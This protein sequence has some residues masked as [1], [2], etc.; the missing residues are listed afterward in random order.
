MSISVSTNIRLSGAQDDT[1]H[2][3]LFFPL[4][5]RKNTQSVMM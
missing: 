5:D 3:G 4:Y 2:K 1:T